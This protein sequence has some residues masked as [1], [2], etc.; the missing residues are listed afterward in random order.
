[1]HLQQLFQNGEVWLGKS[2]AVRQL[3]TIAKVGRTAAYDALKVT[4]GRYS[5]MLRQRDDGK[6]SI[7]LP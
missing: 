6:L 7:S 2:D 3:Q 4:E 5:N 1:L